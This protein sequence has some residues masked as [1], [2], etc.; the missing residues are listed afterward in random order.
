MRKF[1]A[2]FIS[3]IVGSMAGHVCSYQQQERKRIVDGH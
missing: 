1:S 3:L 2:T